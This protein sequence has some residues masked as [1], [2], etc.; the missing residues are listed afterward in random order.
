MLHAQNCQKLLL[1]VLLMYCSSLLNYRTLVLSS[2]FNFKNLSEFFWA[3][4]SKSIAT[5]HLNKAI[6]PAHTAPLD[7][8]GHQSDS[9]TVFFI[10]LCG[11]L[12]YLFTYV[13]IYL[14]LIIHCISKTYTH[15]STDTMGWYT[16]ELRLWHHSQGLQIFKPNRS[17]VREEMDTSFYC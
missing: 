9:L 5:N 7:F 17:T 3:L 11:Y 13:N 10:L 8:I 16:Y 1:N 6:Y 15:F 12:N 4:P 2:S 14:F